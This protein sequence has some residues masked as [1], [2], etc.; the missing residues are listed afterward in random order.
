MD[1]HMKDRIMVDTALSAYPFG[2][3][4]LT[5]M[6]QEYHK[7]MEEVDTLMNQMINTLPKEIRDLKVS[8]LKK[9]NWAIPAS[10][11]EKDNDQSLQRLSEMAQTLVT[12][13]TKKANRAQKT[14]REDLIELSINKKVKDQDDLIKSFANP[15]T[16]ISNNKANNQ[17]PKKLQI[18][19]KAKENPTT[20]QLTTSSITFGSTSKPTA[21]RYED[22]SATP[23]KKM[24]ALHIWR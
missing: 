7:Q 18:K 16:S 14:K 11:Y 19:R 2:L 9:I 13:S 6:E 3:Q 15:S 4:L 21:Q 1:Q 20:N 8:D 24:P 23:R 17:K 12:E 5:E 22:R 10:F